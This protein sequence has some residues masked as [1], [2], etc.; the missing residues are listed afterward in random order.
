MQ[1]LFV[2]NTFVDFCELEATGMSA[3]SMRRT[4]SCESY[5]RLGGHARTARQSLELLPL[6]LQKCERFDQAEQE[7]APVVS[8]KVD[9]AR[10]SQAPRS[11]RSWADIVKCVNDKSED[12]N[13]SM[14]GP[15]TGTE[16]ES[17]CTTPSNTSSLWQSERSSDS[18]EEITAQVDDSEPA[19]ELGR[20]NVASQEELLR[21]IMTNSYVLERVRHHM[22]TCAPGEAPTSIGSLIEFCQR[23]VNEQSA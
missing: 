18:D 7:I 13:V 3:G 16:M 9:A 15:R 8:K 6:V 14:D 19:T 17:S 2:K 4:R 10:P 22:R 1:A 12:A 5:I 20:T 23:L 11:N 21:H